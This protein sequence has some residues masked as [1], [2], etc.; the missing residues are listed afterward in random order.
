MFGGGG[1]LT[2]CDP[3]IQK[4]IFLYENFVTEVGGALSLRDVIYKRPISTFS[5]KI[6][7]PSLSNKCPVCTK[8]S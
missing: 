5:K 6:Q 8:T 3:S 2:L 1:G 4:K 7:R